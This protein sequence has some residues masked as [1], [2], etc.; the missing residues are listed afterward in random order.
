M[1]SK[2]NRRSGNAVVE[3][4]GYLNFVPKSVYLVGVGMHHE[5]V[6]VMREWWG[7]FELYGFEPSPSVYKA[8]K[9]TFPGIIWQYAI[10]DYEGKSK[11]YTKRSWKDGSSLF[12]KK[13]QSDEYNEIEVTVKTLDI[14]RHIPEVAEPALLWLD[15]EGSELNALK[16]AK[17]F[18][19]SVSVVNIEQTQ[20]PRGDDWP[21]PYETHRWLIEHGFL[22]AWTHTHRTVIGQ[23][24]SIYLRR[25]IFNPSWCSCLASTEDYHEWRDYEITKQEAE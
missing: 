11:L 20:H 18:I 7:D 19:Q 16:G 5:E 22:Q 12:E 9:D 23:F 1:P 17:Q 24:D 3:Y 14:M 4:L 25:E 13:L 10:S 15:C 6:D 8:V 2:I 21:T